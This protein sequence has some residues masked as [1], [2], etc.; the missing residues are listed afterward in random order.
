M[1]PPSVCDVHRTSAAM[2]HGLR[3]VR[4]LSS[5]RAGWRGRIAV[6]P[7]RLPTRVVTP[8]RPEEE[9]VPSPAARVRPPKT[10]KA[11]LSLRKNLGRRSRRLRSP[12]HRPRQSSRQK[13]SN[14]QSAAAEARESGRATKDL[15]GSQYIRRPRR[16]D[17]AQ[18]GACP[19]RR[20]GTMVDPP[21]RGF[22]G[23]SAAP[24]VGFQRLRSG[25]A[26]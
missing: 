2:P 21:L 7:V 14:R 11:C 9:G 4:R 19:S 25:A 26:S 24:S 15:G 17:A 5:R 16:P 20:E 1:I 18:G 13:Q 6:R 3:P 8:H 22:A 12:K 10:W 23:R